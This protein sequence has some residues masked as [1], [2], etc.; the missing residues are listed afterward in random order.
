[1]KHALAFD[2]TTYFRIV[3]E[4]LLRNHGETALSYAEDA[5]RKMRILGDDEGF[6]LW[7]GIE[8]QLFKK[9]RERHIPKGAMIH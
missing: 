5:L 9:V 6:E 8:R 3:A 7:S 2:P 4:T 1:M